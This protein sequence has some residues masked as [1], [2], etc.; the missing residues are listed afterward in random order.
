MEARI[1]G[2]HVRVSVARILNTKRVL[3][4][5]FADF[6]TTDHIEEGSSKEDLER[7]VV[8]NLKLEVDRDGAK[9]NGMIL[10]HA[11][12]EGGSRVC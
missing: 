4:A 7:R 12:S 8:D 6:G 11:D 3:P 9:S 2:D 10:D 1:G 5:L